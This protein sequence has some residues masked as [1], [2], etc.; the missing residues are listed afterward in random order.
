MLHLLLVLKTLHIYMNIHQI[1]FTTICTH[2]ETMQFFL[3]HK[4]RLCFF[5]TSDIYD[6]F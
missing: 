6:H 2:L 3:S 1:H 5:M 4:A